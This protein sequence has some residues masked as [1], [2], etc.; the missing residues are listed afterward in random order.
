MVGSGTAY[1][2][3][4]LLIRNR[5][6][7]DINYNAAVLTYHR[8]CYL[9]KAPREGG[10]RTASPVPSPSCT[11]QK[12]IFS[13]SSSSKTDPETGREKWQFGHSTRLINTPSF[14]GKT[15]GDKH[16]HRAGINKH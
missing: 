15:P 14:H 13:S 2:E 8:L 6:D 4:L 3:A 12:M 16:H 7:V 10:R 11:L 9:L 1:I 5:I